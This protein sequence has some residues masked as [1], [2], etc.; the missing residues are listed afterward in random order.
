MSHPVKSSSDLRSKEKGATTE[1]NPS[2][3]S[4]QIA[5]ADPFLP[6]FC[7]LPVASRAPPGS[8]LVDFGRRSQFHQDP[9]QLLPGLLRA[10]YTRI[11]PQD[12]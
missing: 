4:P 12:F 11:P 7:G 8:S 1:R 6:R 5:A 9:L 3:R 2:S 10:V